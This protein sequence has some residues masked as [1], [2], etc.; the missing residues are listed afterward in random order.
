MFIRELLEMEVDSPK[1]RDVVN[2]RE[3][4]QSAKSSMMKVQGEI[5]VKRLD[6]I[7]ANA[8]KHKPDSTAEATKLVRD[9]V[10]G[11]YRKKH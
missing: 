3:V 5:D 11:R 9:M 2:W 4:L 10:L 6:S 1:K 8:K 7:M